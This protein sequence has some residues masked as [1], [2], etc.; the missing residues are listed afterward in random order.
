M[1]K[2]SQIALEMEN[3]IIS[4]EYIQ[5]QKLPSIRKIM[6]QYQCSRWI[7]VKAYEELEKKHLIYAKKQSGYYVADGFLKPIEKQDVYT[8]HTGNPIVSATSL[9]D[10][11][12]C[13]SIAIDQYSHSSLNTSL[14]GV[15]SLRNILPEF[16]SELGI[17]VKKESVYLIQGIT[18]M[19][20][21]FTSY[22]FKNKQ[23]YVL[24]E[25]PT[26]SY[27]VQF[28]KEMQIPTLTIERTEK[29]IDLKKL[30]YIF[31]NYSIKFFYTIPRNHNPLGTI[32]DVKTRQAIAKL[33][34]QY[35]ILI[36]EDDYFGH[37]SST[38]RYLPIYYYMEGKNCIY[39]TSFSKTIPYIR[40]GICVIHLDFIETFKKI[41]N[42]S[43]YYSYQ[44]PSLISQATFESYVRSLLYQKQVE[45]LKQQLKKDYYVI[46]QLKK[47]WNPN[48]AKIITG[49]SGYYLSVCVF[50]SIDLDELEKR[51][52]KKCITIARNERCYYHFPT[53][54]TFRLSLARIHHDDLKKA[55]ELIYQELENMY[56]EVK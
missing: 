13:L 36:I 37:C 45:V 7:A 31:K 4:H 46:E 40:I 14:E 1:Y 52:S 50:Q 15:D 54:K 27:Y 3:K 53:M 41:I 19:L 56:S 5:G 28:L 2:Y 43:Y 12:H 35:D 29:G 16:L 21:F 25:Q 48:I 10:A 17:Y 24:I 18:Q 44:L 22:I 6:E 23:E 11:K 9:Q 51:L 20:S 55:L 49:Y 42:T 39:L 32:L 30:E 33:A 47:V 38:T 26:Y 34:L 8:M